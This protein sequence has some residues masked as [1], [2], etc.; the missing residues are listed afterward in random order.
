MGK[1]TFVTLADLLSLHELEQSAVR[2]GDIEGAVALFDHSQELMALVAQQTPQDIAEGRE[3]LRTAEW[4]LSFGDDENQQKAVSRLRCQIE[5]EG[6][7]AEI[8]RLAGSFNLNSC[9]DWVAACAISSF[10]RFLNPVGQVQLF[11]SATGIPFSSRPP[12]GTIH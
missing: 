2:N 10:F 11:P 7:R 12:L 9:Q 3:Q 1:Q 6:D 5:V 8:Q 4:L